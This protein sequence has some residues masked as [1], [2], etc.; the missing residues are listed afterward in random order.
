MK[1]INPKISNTNLTLMANGENLSMDDA[2]TYQRLFED[3][4][5]YPIAEV[6]L[7][8]ENK[9]KLYAKL[10]KYN[11]KTYDFISKSSN[12][13]IIKTENFVCDVVVDKKHLYVSVF[14]NSLEMAEEIHKILMS[15]E[16]AAAD[17]ELYMDNY[18][19]NAQKTLDYTLKVFKY[20]DFSSANNLFYPYIKTD[21]MFKQLY[22]NKENIMILCGEPGTGKTSLISQL[23]KFTLQNPEYLERSDDYIDDDKYIQVAYVKS[24]EVLSND[25]FWRTLA[26]KGYD[27][28]ILDDLDYFLTSRDQ[29]IQTNEDAERNK[30]LSQF[31][32]FT[33]GIEKNTTNFIITTNQPFDD[34]DSAL[35][36]KGRLFDILELRQLKNDEA[37]VIWESA[38][39][40]EKDFVF[41]GDVL[42]ADLGSEIEKH[43]NKDVE[44]EEYLL[45][46]TVSKLKRFNKKL[47]F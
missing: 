31:L 32:S 46:D 11:Y 47:G 22:T 28:V 39:L 30:F 6:A 33:D 12:Y 23:F 8:V 43:L 9:D 1:Q 26:N 42:Q 40:S 21:S 29:E 4:Y 27:L 18:F 44:I 38:G 36:R 19:L 13:Q 34:I 35:L 7:E 17:I 2:I 10:K 41:E 25:E 16:P 37:L 24:T 14:C 3:G 20:S 45:D 15:L 5:N